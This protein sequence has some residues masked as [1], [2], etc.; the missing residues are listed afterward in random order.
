MVAP[1]PAPNKDT[2]RLHALVDGELDAMAQLEMEERLDADA[3]LRRQADE[4]RAVSAV[5]RES[6][7]YHA[8]PDALR[9]R[10]A[11][12]LGSTEASA[13]S[14]ASDAAAPAVRRPA[15]PSP[16]WAD[17]LS[18][19]LAWRPLAVSM[20]F[21]VLAVIGLNVALEPSARDTRL[22]EAVVASHVRSTVGE[23][24]VDV[25]SSE[26][27][28]VK[29]FLSS[30]LGFSPPV[31]ELRIPGLVFVG[32]RVDYLDNRPVAAL[33]YRQG[34][35]VVNSFVWPSGEADS[36]PTFSVDRGF[37]V[38]HWAAGGMRH[39]VISDVNAEEFRAIVQAVRAIPG[40]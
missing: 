25:A 29:P 10:M 20:S 5:V 33:V 30:K 1:T 4:L 9:R 15:P 14:A 18:Q 23:H 17:R 40:P 12:L 16:G 34:P 35:H 21:A 7:A 24:L 39:W 28:T 3:A 31:D 32:G 38:A 37:Q 11:T 36:T 8:A 2:W 13:S 19:W 27:H 6:A 26:H 22:A